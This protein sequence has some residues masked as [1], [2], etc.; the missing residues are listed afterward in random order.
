MRPEFFR[1]LHAR[2]SENKDIYAI[3]ADLGY[4]G[5]DQIRQDFP[6]RFINT[7][8]AEQLACGLAVGLAQE[9]KIPFFYSIT[10]FLLYRPFEWI[11]NYLD[12]ERAP[13]I[14]VGSGRNNDYKH[15]GASHHAFD[16]KDVMFN[17]F[18]HIKPFWPNKPEQIGRILDQ[19]IE[20]RAPYY[21]NLMR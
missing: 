13:V 4:G 15:D 6:D 3:T 18:K 8:A 14:L 21:L 1:Q 16:D 11:R 19:M 17:V 9:G 5:F 2:M 12:G 7:G 20:V 10:P